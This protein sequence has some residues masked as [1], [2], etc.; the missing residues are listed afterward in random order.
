MCQYLVARR[1]GEVISKCAFEE[2]KDFNN[3]SEEMAK[4]FIKRDY[5][6]EAEKKAFE[7]WYENADWYGYDT[8]EQA[9]RRLNISGDFKEEVVPEEICGSFGEIEI[10]IEE[11]A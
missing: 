2:S 9:M 10:G 3:N 1:Y 5:I 4:I 11:A 7:K 6:G 8:K